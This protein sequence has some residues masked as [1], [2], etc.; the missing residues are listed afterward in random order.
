MASLPPD[1]T[2]KLVDQQLAALFTWTAAPRMLFQ[3]ETSCFCCTKAVFKITWSA[4][5]AMARRMGLNGGVTVT[6]SCSSEL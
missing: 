6:E 2:V 5:M 3:F 4:E 1:R